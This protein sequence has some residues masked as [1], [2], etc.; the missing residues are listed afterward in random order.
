M[1]Q[2]LL[3]VDGPLAIKRAIYGRR[4]EPY[5]IGAH[6][7][8][9]VP[10]TRPFRLKYATSENDWVA[11]YDALQQMYFAEHLKLGHWAVDVGAH[12]GQDAMMMAAL[13][14]PEG[15]VTA[16]EP[17]AEARDT[18][19]K[20][21]A[22]NPGVKPPELVAAACSDAD[23]R[24]MLFNEPGHSANSSLASTANTA[25]GGYEVETIR[26]DTFTKA[27]AP[28][29]IKIDVEG[30]E[31]RVLEGAER[32]L[33]GPTTI[34]CELHPYAWPELGDSYEKLEA[35]LAKHGRRARY[36]DEAGAPSWIRYGITLLE[37]V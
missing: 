1:L 31:I 29:L 21:V 10:G 16:F 30:F 37:R 22:L 25:D 36:L 9:F 28:D 33:A 24:A 17:N 3:R 27:R 14:G 11:R 19:R 20:N 15:L 23:G 5:S 18:F 26:L 32:L 7:L 34:L 12:V 8:R 2:Q 6:R 35:L 4:G 13:C